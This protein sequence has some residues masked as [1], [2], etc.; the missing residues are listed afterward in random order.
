MYIA[1]T[2][3]SAQS[4]ATSMLNTS[5]ADTSHV[6]FYTSAYDTI[7]SRDYGPRYVYEGDVRVIA[8]HKYNRARPND[9]NLPYVLGQQKG[10]KVYE[11]GLNG[12]QLTHGGGNYHLN[13]TGDSY[14]TRLI[15]Q[16][17]PSFTESQIQ[18]IYDTYQNNN[19]TLTNRFPTTVDSTGHIDMWMQIYD[20]NKVF[21]SD[22]PNNS[23]SDQDVI[24][25]N[26]ATLM[27]SRGYQVTRLNA[28]SIGGVHYTFANMAIC[29]NVVLLPQYNGGPGTT[30]SNQMLSVVQ[31]AFGAGKTVYQINA[32]GIVGWAGVF[33][34]IVQHVPVHK[35]L[36][37]ANGGL[38]P[39]ADSARTE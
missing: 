15:T 32:D 37:G 7:W 36:A 23:G 11:M 35:G 31:N 13:A 18:Q 8:D 6:T 26:T 12:T 2:G 5:D 16:E 10:Q 9:D 19:L 22:W 24:C 25:D 33:H 20:D 1:V 17:N 39:T 21:I 14:A 27:Q 30:V 4:E 34:C 29:N 38:A 28:Y 3:P